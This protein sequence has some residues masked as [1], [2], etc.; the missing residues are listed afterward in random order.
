MS[1]PQFLFF[2]RFYR[3]EACYSFSFLEKLV[4]DQFSLKYVVQ[5]PLYSLPMLTKVSR[6]QVP[7]RVVM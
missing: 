2:F 1:L 7:V 3:D 6:I 5:P 4:V